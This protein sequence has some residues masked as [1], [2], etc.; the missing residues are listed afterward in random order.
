MS[1]RKP[2]PDAVL[3]QHSAI[4]GKTG[5]GKT[6]VGKLMVEQVAGED[7]RVCILDPIKSDW[8]GITASADGKKPGLPFTILGGP[9]GHVPLH[10]SAGKAIGQVVANGTLPV[11]VIDMADFEPGG[12]QK[13]FTEF[14]R[15]LLS[16]M[17]GV[18][19]L[20]MEEAHLFAP[21]ERSGIGGENMAIHYA[22]LLATAGRSKGIR[23]IVMTQ[24]TQALH[25]AILGSC[26]TLIAL[27]MTAPADQEPVT[28]WLRSN[29]RDTSVRQEI[30]SSLG[31]IKTGQGWI[32]SGEA[33]LFELKNFALPWTYDNTKTPT[34]KSGEHYVQTAPVD[35][36]KLRGLIG[37][38]VKEAEANDPALL[39]QRIRELERANAKPPI[40]Q[41]VVSE[42][43]AD[44]AYKDGYDTGHS[45]GFSA[46][47]QAAYRQFNAL[48]SEATRFKGLIA[49]A[50]HRHELLTWLDPPYTGKV[51][52]PPKRAMAAAA[53]LPERVMFPD[54]RRAAP[55]NSL[56]GNGTATR[57]PRNAPEGSLPGVQQKVLDALVELKFMGAHDPSRELL[58]FMAG[59]SNLK[60][61]GFANAM[62]ALRTAGLISYPTAGTVGITEEGAALGNCTGVARTPEQLQDRII[63]ML[64]GASGKILAPLISAYP[65]AMDR[66]TLLQ[67]AGYGH[68]KSKGFANALGRLR[69]LGFVD[70]PSTGQVAAQ[71]VLFLEDAP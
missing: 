59:Y 18:V 26:E 47:A 33:G 1:S 64:G 29:V 42:K 55:R 48:H 39:R 63:G 11:S 37:D 12:Q 54:N 31:S 5:A 32:C 44:A 9:R 38:A 35:A 14:A 43:D 24:R 56:S 65:K 2:F 61:K 27:R 15:T 21:K 17:R 36:D 52:M 40:V 41:T 50:L 13:F 25:N 8:W 30:E 53:G 34:S 68:A 6:T 51:R 45:H 20:V 57:G 67:E 16:K 66:E 60:L 71:P 22:K 28:K 3:L 46:G 69:T 62:G 49:D 19:Y 10:S 58:C 4:L 23:L 70:Y 7:Y